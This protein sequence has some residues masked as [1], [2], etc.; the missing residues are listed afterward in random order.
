M[1]HPSD[2]GKARG[3]AGAPDSLLW[4]VTP[5]GQAQPTHVLSSYLHEL[6]VGKGP[7]GVVR[8]V[9]LEERRVELIIAAPQGRRYGVNPVA[10][11]QRV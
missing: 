3:R 1:G 4:K 5:S 7:H 8:D 11:A 10:S 6:K 2:K 9:D